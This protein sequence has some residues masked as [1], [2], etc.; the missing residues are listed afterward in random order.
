[1]I[2]RTGFPL[3]APVPDQ[4]IKYRRLLEYYLKGERILKAKRRAKTR[5]K[6]RKARAQDPL[7]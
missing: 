5:P 7:P 2:D 3:Q 6:E 4:I 1:M